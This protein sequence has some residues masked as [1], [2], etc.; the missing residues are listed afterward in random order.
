MHQLLWKDSSKWINRTYRNLTIIIMM[1]F[2]FCIFANLWLIIWL[3]LTES[4]KQNDSISWIIILIKDT[5]H[6]FATIFFYILLLLRIIAP[7]HLNKFIIYSL[8]MIVFISTLA[9]IAWIL[10]RLL[11]VFM[12]TYN[13]MQEQ[14]CLITLLVSDF[15]LN[16]VIFVIFVIKMKNSVVSSKYGMHESLALIAYK[17]TNVITNTLIKHGLLFGVA[18]FTNQL[19]LI[20]LA[21]SPL[22]PI[23]KINESY[24]FDAA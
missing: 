16:C 1:P 12:D 4:T 7:F 24:L 19:Y 11:N 20:V 8:S 9:S 14:I 10:L 23:K 3:F 22:S 18:I 13:V 15:T 6:Q 5:F 2:T 17:N 21:T